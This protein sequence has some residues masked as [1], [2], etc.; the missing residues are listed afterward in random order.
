MSSSLINLVELAY[1]DNEKT[2]LP[3]NLD[4]KKKR[5]VEMLKDLGFLKPDG[6]KNNRSSKL[7]NMSKKSGSNLLR[8]Q[9]TSGSN[10]DRT[11]LNNSYN[12]VSVYNCIDL[13]IEFVSAL[14]GLKIKNNDFF[15]SLV[16]LIKLYH[17]QGYTMLYLNY[18]SSTA[19]EASETDLSWKKAQY[20][21]QC[22]NGISKL[23]LQEVETCSQNSIENHEM[24][25]SFLENMNIIIFFNV[26]YQEFA[27]VIF[28]LF[29]IQDKLLDIYSADEFLESGNSVEGLTY[30]SLSK[31]VLQITSLFS[32]VVDS[33]N[34]KCPF[35]IKVF[36]KEYLTALLYIFQGLQNF[37]V[38]NK[39][40]RSCGYI[41]MAFRILNQSSVFKSYID[42]YEVVY[43]GWK[44][45]DLVKTKYP[46]IKLDFR[47]E[48]K[49]S[50]KADAQFS[51]E[52]LTKSFKHFVVPLMFILKYRFDSYNDLVAFE[53]V[54]TEAELNSFLTILSINRSDRNAVLKNAKAINWE[55]KNGL[56][57][58]A[59]GL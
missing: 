46:K 57:T 32:V 13:I 21:F 40:G 31:M 23:L 50:F 29:K 24:N 3:H 12:V 52:L 14:Y 10:E 27:Y 4:F 5:I 55:F 28:A 36:Y 11:N 8:M 18:N 19:A 37:T 25:E 38:E 47:K 45:N 1:L 2:P 42:E 41:G 44:K 56:L 30:L 20:C 17:N 39:V 16:F 7:S 49:K 53:T 33:S 35:E 48:K 22:A 6:S 54:P 58:T 34:N 59:I 26:S 43:K 9:F 51:D 15:V